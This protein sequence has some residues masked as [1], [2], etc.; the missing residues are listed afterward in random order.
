MANKG[1]SY[2]QIAMLGRWNAFLKYIKPPYVKYY[3]YLEILIQ[4]ILTYQMPLDPLPH[5]QFM[6]VEP[7]SVRSP[8]TNGTDRYNRLQMDLPSLIRILHLSVDDR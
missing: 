6:P 4:P 3:H 1:Y 2:A 7:P 5:S 8:L